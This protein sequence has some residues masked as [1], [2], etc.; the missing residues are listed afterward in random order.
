MNTTNSNLVISRLRR[1][2]T[3][4][5]SWSFLVNAAQKHEQVRLKRA[6]MLRLTSLSQRPERCPVRIFQQ[7]VERRP[8]EMCEDDSPFYL[9]INHKHKPG[10]Y[11]YKKL[12]LGIHKVDGMM[13]KLAKDGSLTGKKKQLER[14]KFR[15]CVPLTLQTPQSCSFRPQEC[16]ELEPYKRPSL[17]QEKHMSHLLSNYCPS[18]SVKQS[19]LPAAQPSVNYVMSPHP[20]ISES[21]LL[22]V[23]QAVQSRPPTVCQDEAHSPLVNE[24]VQSHPPV[25]SQVQLPAQATTGPAATVRPVRPWPYQFLRE[26][27]GVTWILTW[28]VL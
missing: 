6:P 17:E 10:S 18:S 1:L 13:K 21:H 2:L 11:W 15:H 16:S 22:L 26:K 24:A 7:Y 12:P 27:N 5:N 8:P 14:R 19:P 9:S 25:L 4:Q 20:I 23:N 3:G 28:L